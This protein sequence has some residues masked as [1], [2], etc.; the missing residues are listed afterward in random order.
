MCYAVQNWA[1][2]I[3]LIVILEAVKVDKVSSS[4]AVWTII[5]I[6]SYLAALETDDVSGII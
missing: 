2:F 4:V 6:V 5:C 3:G 1:L